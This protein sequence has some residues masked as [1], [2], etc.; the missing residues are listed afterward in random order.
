MKT[1]PAERNYAERSREFRLRRRPQSRFHFPRQKNFPLSLGDELA[2]NGQSAAP[3][4]CF[5]SQEKNFPL[6]L[7]DELADDGQFG[8]AE[9]PLAHTLR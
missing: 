6:A 2:A 4:F 9:Q 3:S 1:P 5:S 8:S 7:R